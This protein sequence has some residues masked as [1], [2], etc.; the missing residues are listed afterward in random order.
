MP[1]KEMLIDPPVVQRSE[2]RGVRLQIVADVEARLELDETQQRAL[3]KALGGLTPAEAAA[4]LAEDP[5]IVAANVQISPGWLISRV[6][7]NP[8]RVTF[9]AEK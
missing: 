7:E 3:A 1:V 8:D 6:P 2:E 4:V 9:E 5:A